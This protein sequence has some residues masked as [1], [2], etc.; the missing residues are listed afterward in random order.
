MICSTTSQKSSKFDIVTSMQKGQVLV[1]TKSTWLESISFCTSRC[2]LPVC[3]P[4]ICEKRGGHGRGTGLRRE[5]W[6]RG[7]VDQVEK[8]GGSNML[9]QH[10]RPMIC[11]CSSRNSSNNH[12]SVYIY[13]K[14]SV[15]GERSTPKKLQSIIE[16]SK[17]YAWFVGCQTDHLEY[18]GFLPA[19]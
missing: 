14:H 11:Y 9:R 8:E 15:G 12:I 13:M 18:P 5:A 4:L 19:C 10:A 6:A 1:P 17:W 2:I 7:E 3:R 16:R